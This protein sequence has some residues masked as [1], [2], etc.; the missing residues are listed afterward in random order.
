MTH[1]TQDGS[2]PHMTLPN[3][4]IIREGDYAITRE[5]KKVGPLR[6]EYGN[7]PFEW[8]DSGKGVWSDI[9]IDGNVV[10]LYH[11]KFPT[12]LIAKWHPVEPGPDP[13]VPDYN[14]GEWH[15]WHGGECPVHPQSVVDVMLRD[16]VKPGV[17][18]GRS[19][20]WRHEVSIGDIVSFRVVTPYVEPEPVAPPAK[21]R[22]WWIVGGKAFD[23][24]REAK[25]VFPGSTPIK[26][27]ECKQ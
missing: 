24:A 11:I 19:W 3:G 5:G 13:V 20:N 25:T 14:D 12:D 2:T 16:C 26:V 6:H 23:S 9:G 17:R 10:G 4:D 22:K 27:K 1:D 7:P 15:E 8:F 21:R 18:L